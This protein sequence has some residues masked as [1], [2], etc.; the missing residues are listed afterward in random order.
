MMSLVSKWLLAVAIVLSPVISNAQDKDKKERKQDKQ[1][2]K[3]DK[4]LGVSLKELTEKLS[5][6]EEQQKKAK[7]IFQEAKKKVGEIQDGNDTA[8]VM[9]KKLQEIRKWSI[10]K[11]KEILTKEQIEKLPKLIKE[12]KDNARGPGKIFNPEYLKQELELTDEQFDTLKDKTLKGIQQDIKAIRDM[13]RENEAK[14]YTELKSLREE[15]VEDM[16]KI[17]NEK[18]KKKLDEI[19]KQVEKAEHRAK[20]NKKDPKKDTVK[21]DIGDKVPDL[22]FKDINGSEHKLKN[23]S[24]GNEKGKVV[25][26]TFWASQ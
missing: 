18:Q 17:L 4:F 9:E 15:V 22:T 13:C 14:L 11:L 23:Y 26:I 20:K 7:D 19:L 12:K 5:L 25:I 24:L 3:L 1:D 10:D 16:K 2:G 8:K 21:L 6:T